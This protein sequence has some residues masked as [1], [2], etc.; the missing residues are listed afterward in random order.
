MLSVTQPVH[1]GDHLRSAPHRPV[2]RWVAGNAV[3][4]VVLCA[5]SAPLLTTEQD[6]SLVLAAA[7][8]FCFFGPV[9][10]FSGVLEWYL[11]GQYAY[12]S[13]LFAHVAGVVLGML[14]WFSPEE[15]IAPAGQPALG[16]GA[17]GMFAYLLTTFAGLMIAAAVAAIRARRRGG[18]PVAAPDRALRVL[19]A[20]FWF[21]AVFV[22]VVAIAIAPG[23]AAQDDG[24]WGYGFAGGLIIA[25]LLRLPGV[26]AEWLL[27]KRRLHWFVYGTH[28]V[29]ALFALLAALAPASDTDVR[30]DP[31]GG[32]V[33]V[34]LLTASV[35]SWLVLAV[36]A[37]IQ[38]LRR[39]SAARTAVPPTSYPVASPP[40]MYP[41]A[42]P[43]PL[44]FPAAPPVPHPAALPPRPYPTA[45]DGPAPVIRATAPIPPP[46][47]VIVPARAETATR[48]IVTAAPAQENSRTA[49]EAKDRTD[50]LRNETGVAIGIVAGL[51][52]LVQGYDSEQIAQ[53]V[54]AALLVGGCGLGAFYLFTKRG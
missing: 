2:G 5:V 35:G 52:S 42:P 25:V 21:N 41:A 53:T 51:A 6:P 15:A 38:V 14:M 10:A 17:V 4:V 18:R 54:V 39:R 16:T 3:A 20:L 36:V 11:A 40:P 48:P 23:F 33:G 43:P 32:G 45:G 8:S 49:T 22:V 44:S 28:L 26:G 30:F 50:R 24:S 19:P 7:L 1:I 37:P 47:P 12:R 13:L 27:T 46:A 29:A 34:Y 9:R 31:V